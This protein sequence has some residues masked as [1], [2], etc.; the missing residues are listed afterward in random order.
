MSGN[1]GVFSSYLF[2][3]TSQIGSKSELTDSAYESK[4]TLAAMTPTMD[5][6]K[7]TTLDMFVRGE[8]GLIFGFPSA[9]MDLEKAYKRA[10]AKATSS[11]ILTDRI[12]QDSAS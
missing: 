3:G 2:Y 12:L 7:T 6:D 8:I 4:T 5:T 1:D 9:I 10:G 11:T